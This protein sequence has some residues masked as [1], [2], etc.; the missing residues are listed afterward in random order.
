MKQISAT[1]TTPT[2]RTADG[3]TLTSFYQTIDWPPSLLPFPPHRLVVFLMVIKQFVIQLLLALASTLLA[4]SVGGRPPNQCAFHWHWPSKSVTGCRACQVRH[5]RHFLPVERSPD[6]SAFPLKF[7]SNDRRS[8]LTLLMTLT[9]TAFAQLG[10][11]NGFRI[12]LL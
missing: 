4:G 7:S 12:T 6:D 5:G 3:K 9:F 11:G 1:T 2:R 8:D 10:D